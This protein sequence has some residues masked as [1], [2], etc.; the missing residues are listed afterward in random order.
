[1]GL[2]YKYIYQSLHV[3]SDYGPIIRRNNRV[4]ATLGTCYSVRMTVWYAGWNSIHVTASC[5][6]VVCSKVSD[7]NVASIFRKNF[8]QHRRQ[9]T[10]YGSFHRPDCLHKCMKEMSYCKTA[11]T[12]LPEDEHLDVRNMSKTL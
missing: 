1:M 5:N 9:H 11:C 12:S 2:L 8:P 3:S 6:V 10:K 7:E 4:F